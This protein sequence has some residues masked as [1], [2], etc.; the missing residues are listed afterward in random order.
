M[1]PQEKIARE[2]LEYSTLSDLFDEWKLTT[3][4][5]DPYIYMVRGWL[6][7]EF[8]R[9]NPEGFDKWLEGEALDETLEDYILS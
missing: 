7:D 5:N 2:I 9:R 8:K 6:M 4:S 1:L 3:E